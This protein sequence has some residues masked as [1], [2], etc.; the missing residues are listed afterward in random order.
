MID[1]K[2]LERLINKGA[3][4]YEAKY[5]KINEVSLKREI[6]FVDYKSGIISFEPYPGEKYLFHKY[7][8]RLFETKPEANWF[9]EFGDIKNSDKLSLPYYKNFMKEYDK[10]F[11]Y[12]IQ[13][14][15]S[16]SKTC[17]KLYLASLIEKI[18]ILDCIEKK[19]IFSKKNNVKNY[20]DACRL[21]KK[22]YL[23]KRGERKWEIEKD[24]H[25]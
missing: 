7:L 15:S 14:Y 24:F 22:L 3:T 1:K 6:R 10:N 18:V 25:Q 20:T 23:E 17:Y 8:K 12:S 5:G 11:H 21:C 4:I 19:E 2:R 9:L 13:F 16:K